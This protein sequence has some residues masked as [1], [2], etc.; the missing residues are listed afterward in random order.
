MTP[1]YR[2]SELRIDNIDNI[3]DRRGRQ[4]RVG[5]SLRSWVEISCRQIIE[6]Y[7]AIA[8]V[9][10]DGVEIMPV[11]KADAYNHG[12]VEVSRVLAGEGV[13]WLAV[14]SADEG[15][16]LRRAGIKCGIVLM[17]DFLPGEREAVIEYDLT[18][19]LH[20]LDQMRH[21]SAMAAKAQRTL[22]YH[23][24]IDSGLSRLGTRANCAEITD[25]LRAAP[26]II[27]QGLMTHFASAEDFT[28][29]Q[30][31]EQ[32]RTFLELCDGLRDRVADPAFIHLSSTNAV[33]Y[34]RRKAWQSLVRPGLSLYGYISS[35][36][37]EAPECLLK[38]KPALTW[39]AAVLAIKDLPAGALVGYNAQFRT[40]R[41]TRAA[42]LAAGYADGYPHNL[43]NKGK[44]IVNGMLAPVIG[45]VSMDLITIDITDCPPLAPG[46]AVTLLG[47]QNSASMDALDVSAL[48]GTIPYA[49]LCGIGKRVNRLYVS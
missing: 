3:V 24:K 23:L 29:S 9:T 10:G 45:A 26:N 19:V 6:N 8:A 1:S 7:R 36:F 35:S 34:G 39:K 44:V 21:L 20:S 13:R 28:S 17:A 31:D 37:G 4:S 46:D 38:V 14:A 15:V 30:T 42:V 18:P 2:G 32:I 27:L 11:V 47:R 22:P 43:R 16:A 41:P 49:V 40:Q 48:A 33:A 25:A 12:A 5:D